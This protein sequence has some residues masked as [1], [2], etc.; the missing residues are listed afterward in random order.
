MI[1][2]NIIKAKCGLPSSLTSNQ[3]I[4]VPISKVNEFCPQT[5]EI[6]DDCDAC[7]GNP[8]NNGGKCM[9]TDNFRNVYHE[10]YYQWVILRMSHNK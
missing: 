8:C 1:N 10:S 9:N 4:H 5:S 7:E 3:L 6:W 2:Y